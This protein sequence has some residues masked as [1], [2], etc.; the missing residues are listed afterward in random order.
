MRLV[1]LRDQDGRRAVAASIGAGYRRLE[2]IETVYELAL[3]SIESGRALAATASTYVGAREVDVGLA[4]REGRLLAP[5]DHPVPTRC[6]VTAADVRGDWYFRGNGS[7]LVGAGRPLPCPSAGAHAVLPQLAG[8]FVIAEDGTPCRVGFAL[9]HPLTDCGLVAGPA[10][11]HARLR[12]SALGPELLPGELPADLAA[13]AAILR[14]EAEVRRWPLQL[15]PAAAL[16][17]LTAAHFRYEMHRRP[18]DVHAHFFGP[19]AG[20]DAVTAEPGDTC[21]VV[22]AAF[23]HPLRSRLERVEATAPAVRI[24]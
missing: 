17:E 7:T 12:A 19:P 16:E 18:G 14:G 13:T 20:S 8:L 22:A 9:G 24:V 5:L 21:E 2:D 1:Q 15:A 4:E 3:E 11:G 6:W 10:A 23:G